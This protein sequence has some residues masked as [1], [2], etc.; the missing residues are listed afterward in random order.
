MELNGV[1]TKGEGLVVTY[2][3]AYKRYIFDKTWYEEALKLKDEHHR[4]MSLI[5]AYAEKSNLLSEASSDLLAKQ[6]PL[7]SKD[8]AFGAKIA[9]QV[10]EKSESL[11][12][13]T[14]DLLTNKY[15]MTYVRPAKS[16]IL[17]L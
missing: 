6:D 16:Y 12:Q 11:S 13:E 3:K 15:K 1:K 8:P 14:I 4:Q 7:L 2:Q 17:K 10:V 5:L 9:Y